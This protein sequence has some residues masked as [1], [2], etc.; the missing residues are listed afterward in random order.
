MKI[1]K[2]IEFINEEFN[3]TPESYIETALNQIKRKIDKMFDY[4]ID[5][6]NREDDGEKKGSIMKAK[7]NSK[8]KSKITFKDLG[9][10]LDSS[11]ISKYSK[12]YD[13]LTVKFSDVNSSYNLLIFIDIKEGMPKDPNVDFSFEDVE[14]C[15]VKFKK[16][17]IETFEVIG[18]MTKN[19]KIKDIDEEFLIDLKIELD[20][21][22][23]DEDEKLEIETE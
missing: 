9:I 14:N 13:S 5:L 21:K 16:Y 15:F 4:Q 19:I 6:E 3:D 17:D 11:E 8:D 22:F 7:S 10:Q 23:G 12:M 2:F 1:R 18:Q 20:E